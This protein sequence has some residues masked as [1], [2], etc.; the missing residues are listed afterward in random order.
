[1][2]KSR[3]NRESRMK[4]ACVLVTAAGSIVSQGIIKAL[5]LAS[6]R[7]ST[8]SVLNYSI[9]ATDASPL[10]AGIYRCDKGDIVPEASSP[11]YIDSIIKI[12]RAND[13][14]AIFV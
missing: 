6:D 5:K 11:D 14:E 13:I 10:A 3:G 12:C 1:M 9:T 7:S 8:A 2:L 4:T